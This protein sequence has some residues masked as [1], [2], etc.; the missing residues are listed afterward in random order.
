MKTKTAVNVP[1][2]G[3]GSSAMRVSTV[4]VHCPLHLFYSQ[5]KS[6]A[7]VRSTSAQPLPSERFDF[8]FSHIL[9]RFLPRM[10]DNY[11][12]KVKTL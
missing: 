3:P 11:S 5:H 4:K 6:L 7:A 8:Q 12:K 9:Q 1:L 2:D 10:F